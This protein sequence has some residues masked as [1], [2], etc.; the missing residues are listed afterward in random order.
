MSTDNFKIQ[1][2]KGLLE[3]CILQIISR[4]E[5]YTSDI[6]DELKN[7]EIIVVEGTL[8]PLL[9]RLKASGYVDYKW[10]ESNQGPPRKYYLLTNEG[11]NH[12][13]GLHISWLELDKAVNKIIKTKKK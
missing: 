4:G 5:V 2:R 6:I 8:Y 12:L 1:I 7:S 13:K 10:K 11:D 9:N 3:F